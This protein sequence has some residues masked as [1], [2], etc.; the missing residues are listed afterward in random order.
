M[1]EQRSTIVAAAPIP[2]ALETLVEVAKVGQVPK[3]RTRTGFS[4]IM[5][6]IKFCHLLNYS[7]S[8]AVLNA[9]KASAM[10]FLYAVEEM[11][12]PE[13]ASTSLSV[14]EHFPVY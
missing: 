11:V 13:I 5:P 8:F 10:A 6:L 9:V 3:I 4:L 12:A 1:F 14:S 7:A 2:K